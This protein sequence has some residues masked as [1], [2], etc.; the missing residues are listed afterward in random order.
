MLRGLAAG[1]KELTLSD[2]LGEGSAYHTVPG[3]LFPYNNPAFGFAWNV[4]LLARGHR[5]AS[6]YAGSE[7]RD[8]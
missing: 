8:A 1:P 5:P 4:A 2:Y 7:P 3:Y 6:Q